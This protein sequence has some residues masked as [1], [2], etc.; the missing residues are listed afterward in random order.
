MGGNETH[1]YVCLPEIGDDVVSS[2]NKHPLFKRHAQNG[3]SPRLILISRVYL[4]HG[5]GV[6]SLG[7]GAPV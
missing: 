1:R 3:A 5:G 6:D 7:R 4:S 2:K